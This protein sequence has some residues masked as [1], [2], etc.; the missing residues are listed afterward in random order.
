MSAHHIY[1]RRT[2]ARKL[3][4]E[5]TELA[6]LRLHPEHNSS[7]EEAECRG[8]NREFSYIAKIAFIAWGMLQTPSFSHCLQ[9]RHDENAWRCFLHEF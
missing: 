7:A 5:A 2:E 9:G 8:P 1:T 3:R 6:F 4:E